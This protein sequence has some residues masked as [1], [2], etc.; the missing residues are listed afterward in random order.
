M[1][2]ENIEIKNHIINIVANSLKEECSKNERLIKE[3]WLYLGYMDSTM[4]HIYDLIGQNIKNDAIENIGYGIQ[5]RK[6]EIRGI[7]IFDINGIELDYYIYNSPNDQICDFVIK[8]RYSENNY[9]EENKIL[10]VTIYTVNGQLIEENS[11]KNLSHELNHILQISK[12]SSKN[13]NYSLLV[14]GAYNY[15]SEIITNGKSDFYDKLIAW[16]IYYSNP[17]GQDSFMNGY[18]Q[19]L[20]N[21]KQFIQNKDSE[22]YKRLDDYRK[23]CQQFKLNINNQELKMPF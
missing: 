8:E 23:R 13:R 20:R 4:E 6:G 9:D 1:L 10:S 16:L 2:N 22:T 11:N 7:T 3:H 19:D 14:N 17:H 15:A 21:H 5:F 12:G 18:Y